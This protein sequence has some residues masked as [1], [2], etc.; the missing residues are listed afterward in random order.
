MQPTGPASPDPWARSWEDSPGTQAVRAEAMAASDPFQ[1]WDE[2]PIPLKRAV[3]AVNLGP[4]GRSGCIHVRNICVHAGWLQSG[5]HH[6][7]LICG[8]GR[9]HP[10]NIAR[11]IMR[12]QHATLNWNLSSGSRTKVDRDEGATSRTRSSRSRYRDR[13]GT[14][15]CAVD[16][17]EQ[18]D[19]RSN[20]FGLEHNG[21]RCTMLLQLIGCRRSWLEMTKS[22]NL[23]L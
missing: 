16:D 2:H 20:R 18:C 6:C 17:G 12:S 22:G 11:Q 5:L 7:S 13:V 10:I 19:A 15:D 14:I 1:G 23:Y 9:D 21:R 8:I 3:N 4:V